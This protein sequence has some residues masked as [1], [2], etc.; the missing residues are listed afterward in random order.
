MFTE[1]FIFSFFPLLLLVFLLVFFFHSLF[2]SSKL[3][4]SSLLTIPLSLPPIQSLGRH[5]SSTAQQLTKQL[6][7]SN[8]NIENKAH[9]EYETI[10]I[11]DIDKNILK[12]WSASIDNENHRLISEG[13]NRFD[14]MGLMNGSNA[15][16]LI[17]SYQLSQIKEKESTGENKYEFTCLRFFIQNKNQNDENNEDLYSASPSPPSSPSPSHSRSSNH[18]QSNN[19]Y[20]LDPYFQSNSSSSS[21]STDDNTVALCFL[22]IV[23]NYDFSIY[24]PRVLCSL[25]HRVSNWLGRSKSLLSVR[26]GML[27]F[28]YPFQPSIFLLKSPTLIA[29]TLGMKVKSKNNNIYD[30]HILI[31]RLLLNEVLDYNSRILSKNNQ[32]MNVIMSLSKKNYPLYQS[33]IANS[34]YFQWFRIPLPS[35]F[36]V[37]LRD[38]IKQQTTWPKYLQFLRKMNKRVREAPFDKAG[39]KRIIKEEWNK[40]ESEQ[41]IDAHNNVSQHRIA[42]DSTPTIVHPSIHFIESLREISLQQSQYSNLN[43]QMNNKENDFLLNT[44]EK[45]SEDRELIEA[46][47][48]KLNDSLSL[49]N[50]I[51]KSEI[52]SERRER[53]E[54]INSSVSSLISSNKTN[55]HLNGSE[56]Q[57][58]NRA[59]EKGNGKE[60]E[61]S[62]ENRVYQSSLNGLFQMSKIVELQLGG[63]K[64]NK[65]PITAA[66]SVLFQFYPSLLTSDISGM[67]YSKLENYLESTQS[68]IKL[69]PVKLATV[70]RYALNNGFQFVEFGLF[71]DSFPCLLISLSAVFTEFVCF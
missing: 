45:Y 52:E 61:K 2:S 32:E 24:F 22:T 6:S 29:Q 53:F 43:T 16:K 54:E 21:Y 51:E 69:Y 31:N 5:L 40:E 58:R 55:Q 66:S 65:T 19:N 15:I 25:V 39:G 47:K 13:G 7:L 12:E 17:H 33:I 46:E 63:E 10:Q 35:T 18:L 48:H 68:N 62:N 14:Y 42:K 56:N 27:G 36:I 37:D 9:L 30:N 20:S 67:N 44:I 60:K 50:N 28:H 3:G 26:F 34:H 23:N 49:F 1:S 8:K 41:L 38:H 4:N 11:K 59:K 70:V 57:N 71:L 64:E